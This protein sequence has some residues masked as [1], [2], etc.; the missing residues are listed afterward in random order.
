MWPWTTAGTRTTNVDYGGDT[1]H[2]R[3]GLNG[4]CLEDA[5]SS[6]R[7]RSVNGDD[8]AWFSPRE[9]EVLREVERGISNKEI[10]RAL[11][12]TEHTV[13]FHLK[14]IFRK[15]YVGRRTEA[16]KVARELRVI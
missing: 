10:A 14:N 5:V 8:P 2:E 3:V 7:S 11:S 16:L 4:T 6:D 1:H 9:L 12:M 15:L 13:K